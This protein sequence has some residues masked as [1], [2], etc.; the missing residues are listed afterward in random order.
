MSQTCIGWILDVYFEYDQVVLW[1]KS[2]IGKGIKLVADYCPSFFLLPKNEKSG[3]ELVQILSDLE[4]VKKVKWD[5]K[6]TD[7]NNKTKQ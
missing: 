1:I 4:P 7:I 5:Y 3:S 2:E 6:F